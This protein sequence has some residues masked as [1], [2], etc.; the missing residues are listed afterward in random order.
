MR[1]AMV[2]GIGLLVV[3][4]G[5]GEPET[6]DIVTAAAETSAATDCG[7][8]VLDQGARLSDR[9][10]ACFLDA[11]TAGDPATLEVT[12]PTTEGDPITQ[13][14]RNLES[15]GIQVQTDSTKDRLGS[16]E[17][18]TQVCTGPSRSSFALTF[19]ECH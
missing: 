7:T 16:G 11:V 8:E 6:V 19:E 12:Y 13:V 9:G 14:F 1:R 5:C 17:V 2:V 3:L 10:A 18:E 4:A 15:G